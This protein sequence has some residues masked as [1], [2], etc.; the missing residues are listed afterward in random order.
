MAV[1]ISEGVTD[2][3]N[4]ALPPTHALMEKGP[5]VHERTHG[6]VSF[7]RF[8]AAWGKPYKHGET[9][10]GGLKGSLLFL[11]EYE[12]GLKSNSPDGPARG[13]WARGGGDPD[14]VGVEISFF[15][16]VCFF[17]RK[18][19]MACDPNL[20]A[21]IGTGSITVTDVNENVEV[22]LD[23]PGGTAQ[24]LVTFINECME[25]PPEGAEIP[26]KTKARRRKPTESPAMTPAPA[27]E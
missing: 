5:E 9:E 23:D 24:S 10:H 4:Q 3:L 25:H 11:V 12:Q 14:I 18:P 16:E 8:P 13:E 21:A 17:S 7:E 2:A 22:V 20:K 19:G 6:Y 27:G 15:L 1:S 26:V